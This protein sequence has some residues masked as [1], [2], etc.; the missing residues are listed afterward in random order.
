MK[1]LRFLV[2]GLLVFALLQA[3]V[4]AQEVGPRYA[5]AYTI[6]PSYTHKGNSSWILHD[7][8]QGDTVKDYLTV[9]NLSSVAG[10][11]R[12]Y[13]VEGVE[14]GEKV[15]TKD[16]TAPAEHIGNLVTPYQQIVE[17]EA[18][19]KTKIEFSYAIPRDFE[20]GQFVGVFYAEPYLP[21][22]FFDSAVNIKTRVGVRMYTNVADFTPSAFSAPLSLSQKVFF[23]LSTIL[24]LITFLWNLMHYNSKQISKRKM[25]H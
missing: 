9:E 11:F 22:E 4:A 17:L 15:F 5:S 7:V 13:F 24:L 16:E 8:K 20:E 18:G 19:E 21:A 6:Y 2:P 3:T 25:S 23:A 14:E 12:V 10:S 1:I